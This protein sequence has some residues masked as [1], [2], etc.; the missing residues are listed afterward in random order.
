VSSSQR[1][2]D[3]IVAPLV[4]IQTL[5]DERALAALTAVYYSFTYLGFAA[6]YLLALAAHFASY[7][8]LLAIAALLALTTAVHTAR[9]ES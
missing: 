8:L 2:R 3:G 7:T 5:T 6:P 4:E 1:E 9:Q